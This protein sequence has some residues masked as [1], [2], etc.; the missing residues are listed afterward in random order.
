[1]NKNARVLAYKDLNRVYER[2]KYSFRFYD[3]KTK[4][5]DAYANSCTKILLTIV[6]D[7]FWGT[8]NDFH[9]GNP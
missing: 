1:M 3:G 7:I 9:K 5:G 8:S 6:L 2:Y 4:I